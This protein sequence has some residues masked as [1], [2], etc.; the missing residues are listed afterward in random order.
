M[1]GYVLEIMNYYNEIKTQILN[2]EI[3]KKLRTILKI[4]VI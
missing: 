3:T 1:K 2:N 4:R